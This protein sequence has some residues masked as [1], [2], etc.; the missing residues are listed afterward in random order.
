VY[1]LRWTLRLLYHSPTGFI[2][3]A[4]VPDFFRLSFIVIAV[5]K[6]LKGKLQKTMH[7][8]V[9]VMNIHRQLQ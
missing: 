6:S 1:V 9:C 8:V 5:N 4:G 7:V 2:S 3:G